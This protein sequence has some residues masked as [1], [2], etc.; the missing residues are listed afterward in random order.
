MKI[1]NY[2]LVAAALL[3]TLSTLEA[4][5]IKV[6]KEALYGS[7]INVPVTIDV[8]RSNGYVFYAFN[9][10][11]YD[12]TVHL[13]ITDIVNLTPLKVDQNFRVKPG[14]SRLIQSIPKRDRL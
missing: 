3:A 4:Q 9:E 10:S 13:T 5:T 8:E 12:Y 6:E 1:N 7:K 2:L 11:Y 14:R